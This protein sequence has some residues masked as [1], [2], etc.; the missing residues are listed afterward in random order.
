[1]S[2]TNREAA[3][4]ITQELGKALAEAPPA[5]LTQAVISMAAVQAAGA[6]V[7]ATLALADSVEELT[8]AIR[9]G[10]KVSAE[11]RPW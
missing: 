8:R 2:E 9:I 7:Y 6:Q 3:D 4:R 5:Q 1:M 11:E 10:L